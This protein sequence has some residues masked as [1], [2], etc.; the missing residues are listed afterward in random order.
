MMTLALTDIRSRK[1]GMKIEVYV[2]EF[3]DPRDE[4]FNYYYINLYPQ[5]AN[6]ASL[7]QRISHAT[8]I[9]IPHVI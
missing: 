5:V 1:T 4:S 6:N 2:C 7:V 8:P 3:G 9:L